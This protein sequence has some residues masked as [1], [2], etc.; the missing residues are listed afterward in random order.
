MVAAS[1]GGRL[2]RV[3][4]GWVVLAAVLRVAVV[5]AEHCPPIDAA[6]ADAAARRGLE[7]VV[8]NQRDDG[9]F[10]YRYD[11]DRGVDLGGYNVV[12]HAGTTMALY[13]YGDAAFVAAADRAADWLLDRL[14]PAGG[15]AA[16]A[17]DGAI[18]IGTTALLAA[19]LV[20]RHDAMVDGSSARYDAELARLVAFLIA[21]VHD[22]GT[23]VGEWDPERDRAVPGTE[24]PFFTGE[25]MW[26]LAMA[27][28]AQGD[29]AATAAA[30]RVLADVATERDGRQDHWPPIAD[31]WA[32]YAMAELAAAGERLT[33][34]EVDYA[35]RQA[36]AFG[37]QIRWESQ[38][39]NG[40]VSRLVRGEQTYG[41]SLATVGEGLGNLWRLAQLD[42]RLADLAGPLA[43]RARCGAGMLHARQATEPGSGPEVRG[44][45]FHHGITQVDD[46]QH[47]ASAL[48]LAARIMEAEERA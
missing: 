22:D 27:G 19:G 39:T 24:S 23:V 46:Q 37:I 31:H 18:K 29:A 26:A 44:A 13:Q 4:L 7:W 12:R 3:G 48:W 2:V 6:A 10:L 45:W 11:R 14:V 15:G 47:A 20:Y 41:A 40:S 43:E 8:T 35:R 32:A 5:P 42:E 28:R 33:P 38:R 17:A 36:G 16:V 9:T 21:A 1:P 25:A 30:R 34:D